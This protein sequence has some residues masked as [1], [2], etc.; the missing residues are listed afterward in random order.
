[1]RDLACR[2]HEGAK[3][4]VVDNHIGLRDREPRYDRKVGDA[5]GEERI[6]QIRG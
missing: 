6:N 1:M 2:L 4:L 5:P 3:Y